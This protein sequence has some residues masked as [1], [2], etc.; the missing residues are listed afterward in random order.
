MGGRST[1]ISYTLDSPEIKTLCAADVRLSILIR[2]YGDLTYSLHADAFAFLIETIIGQMLSS[3]V[4]DVIAARFYD[5]CDNNVA[6]E[7]VSKLHTSE[8]R[9]I[10]LSKQKA[11][12]ILKLAAMSLANPSFFDELQD[13]PDDVVV[14]SLTSLRGIGT[15]SA[16]MYLIF[17]LDR[18][19][20]L[21]YEDGAFL[22]AYKWLYTTDDIKPQVIKQRCAP[23]SPYA[24]LAA[25]YFY[26]ALDGG[27]MQ[28]TEL[29]MKYKAEE[30]I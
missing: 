19:D 18:M 28:D 14:K 21:P 20:V 7:T 29:A 27:L 1:T 10:G 22:Q 13:V 26:R 9:V 5:L 30:S 15:W 8:L 2:H 16:K 25:R 12:Y 3:K 23:W 6:A 4:A 11:E 24:S 17:V